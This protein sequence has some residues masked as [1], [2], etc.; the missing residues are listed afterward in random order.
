MDTT[1]TTANLPAPENLKQWADWLSAGLH[2]RNRHRLAIVLT[3]MLFATGRRTVSAWLRAAGICDDYRVYYYF[4]GSIGRNTQVIADLLVRRILRAL[5]ANQDTILVA[6]DDTPTKRYGPEVEGCGLHKNPTPGPSEHSWVYGHVWVTMAIVLRHPLWKTIALPILSKLYVRE[7]DIEH[8]P[9]PWEFQTKLQQAVQMVNWMSGLTTFLGKKLWIVVDGAYAKAPFLKPAMKQG[10][11]VISR[12]RKDAALRTL[13]AKRKKGQRGRPRKYGKQKISLARRSRQKQGWHS[14][15]CLLYQ[16]EQT[17]EYKT[18]LATWRP[19]GGVIRV[20]LVR[21]PAGSG[22]F[23]VVAWFSTDPDVSVESILMSVAD[24]GSIEQLFADVK[25]VWGAGQQQVRN[26]WANIG[27]WHLNLWM[28]TLVEMWAWTKSH[29]QLVDRSASPWDT[30]SRR[31]SHAD[32][33]RAWQQQAL[34]E[35]FSTIND[36]TPQSSKIKQCLEWLANLAF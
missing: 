20:V 7:K 27:C 1:E 25:E 6:I 2:G 35:E 31:P 29:A 11:V 9:Q 30:P 12:L 22:R 8:I 3:G 26:I 17:L 28:S 15:S 14:I 36:S 21:W 13:P 23:H 18:F 33:R 24:R 16:R 32:R 34:A 10:A 5:L 19:V 4:I